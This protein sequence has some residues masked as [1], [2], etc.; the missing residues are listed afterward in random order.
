MMPVDDVPA[1]AVLAIPLEG[2]PST[3]ICPANCMAK[4]SPDGTR[5]YVQPFLEGRES[6]RAVLVPTAA[7]QWFNGLPPGGIASAN[8]FAGSVGTVSVDLTPFDP[9]HDGNNVAPGPTPDV[10]AYTRSVTHRN[11]FQIQL[12]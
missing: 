10:F 5:L 11:L 8:S 4:W 12:P 2:G 6:G 7:G 9:G 1:T 3:R